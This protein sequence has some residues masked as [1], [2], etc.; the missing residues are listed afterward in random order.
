MANV[1]VRTGVYYDERCSKYPYFVNTMRHGR[2][3]Y[4]KFKTEE[5]AVLARQEFIRSMARKKSGIHPMIFFQD[6]ELVL[7]VSF[8]RRYP[9]TPE[10]QKRALRVAKVLDQLMV[11]E[12]Q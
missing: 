11:E 3:F 1:R 7:E 6:G 5:E 8:L 2:V 10:G 9:D 4:K 12:V